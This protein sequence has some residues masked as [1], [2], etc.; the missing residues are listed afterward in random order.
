M[1]EQ[2]TFLPGDQWLYY[3]IYT[4]TATANRLLMETIAPLS[5]YLLE[6]GLIKKWFFIRYNDPEFHLRVRFQVNRATANTEMIRL[7]NENMQNYIN[8]FMVWKIQLDTYQREL[9]RYTLSNYDKTEEIFYLDSELS[10]E[11]IENAYNTGD[12]NIEWLGGLK[13]IDS[14]LN[15]IFKKRL[16]DKLKFIKTM[17][18]SF[19]REFQMDKGLKKAINTKFKKY[20]P[21]IQLVIN[22]KWELL[23]PV[24]EAVRKRDEQVKILIAGENLNY[25]SLGG[26]IHMMMNRLFKSDNRKHEL[27]MYQF[28]FLYYRMLLAQKK[29]QKSK[30]TT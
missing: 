29:Y 9:E 22:E 5:H 27:V 3:K 12:E 14:F 23:N 15:V 11:M 28:L 30:P 21:V 10:K 16:E 7:L 18:D 24:Y 20:L 1:Q 13:S 19:A 26:M 8:N 6:K 2:R 4:G 25:H 17:A